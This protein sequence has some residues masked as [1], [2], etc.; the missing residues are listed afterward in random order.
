[1]ILTTLNLHQANPLRRRESGVGV[2]LGVEVDFIWV[3]KWVEVRIYIYIYI[4]YILI[5]M[6]KPTSH[7]MLHSK[8]L[9]MGLVGLSI[10]N[11]FWLFS[12]YKM[13]KMDRNGWM[14]WPFWMGKMYMYV[15]IEIMFVWIEIVKFEIKI[16]FFWDKRNLKW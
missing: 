15:W 12:F 10:P 3:S 16:I 6:M 11:S 1:M 2:G 4:W 13:V 7:S 5:D 8:L 14:A 9:S